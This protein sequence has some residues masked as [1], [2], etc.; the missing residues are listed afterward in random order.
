MSAP[1]DPV[2]E[3]GR[4]RQ[5]LARTR[6]ETGSGDAMDLSG[7][8]QRLDRVCREVGAWTRSRPGKDQGLSVAREMRGFLGDLESLA[9][10]LEARHGELERRLEALGAEPGTPQQG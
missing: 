7:L 1:F 3:L 9:A 4:L 5:A 8:E 10:E 6:R 2:A